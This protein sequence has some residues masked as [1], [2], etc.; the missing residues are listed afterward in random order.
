MILVT[1][2]N[3]S[4]TVRCAS[5]EWGNS[6]RRWSAGLPE[7]GEDPPAPRYPPVHRGRHLQLSAGERV[8]RGGHLGYRLIGPECL[9][10]EQVNQPAVVQFHQGIWVELRQPGLDLPQLVHHPRPG[11]IGEDGGR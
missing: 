2:R 1:L 6:L 9:V 7:R 10:V 8:D 4:G 11:V 3:T 5:A